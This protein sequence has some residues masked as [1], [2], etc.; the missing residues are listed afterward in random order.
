[1]SLDNPDKDYEASSYVWVE[2]TK[3]RVVNV[4]GII[5]PVTDNLW[6]ALAGFRYLNRERVLWVDAL[7]IDQSNKSEPF[8]QVSYMNAIY[9]KASFVE[10]WLGGPEEDIEV[11]LKLIKEFA[12][13]RT[14]GG[15]TVSYAHLEDGLPKDYDVWTTDEDSLDEDAREAIEFRLAMCTFAEYSWFERVWTVQEFF[16][17]KKSTFYCGTY[18]LHGSIFM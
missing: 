1:M 2:S 8:D 15:K 18:V 14:A 9:S 11:A 10:I 5:M 4:S 13:G 12:T 16:L 7:C 17:A 6:Q 3:G